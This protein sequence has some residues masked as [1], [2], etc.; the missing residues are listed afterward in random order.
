MNYWR[1]QLHPSDPKR[2]AMHAA[3]SLVAGFIGLDFPEDPGDLP[4]LKPQPHRTGVLPHELTFATKMAVDDKVLVIVH[5][6]P[7]ALATVDGGY[8]YIRIADPRLRVWFRHYRRVRDVKFYADF[9]TNA[10]D[11]EMIKMTGTVQVLTDPESASYKMIEH[12][13]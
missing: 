11:W 9:V 13:E 4:L 7:F 6:L 8:N 10:R 5:H 1:M 3:E 12:W 2:A